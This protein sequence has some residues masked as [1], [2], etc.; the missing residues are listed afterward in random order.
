MFAQ[1]RPQ[2]LRGAE[3]QGVDI[4]VAGLKRLL[5]GECEQVLGQ[6]RAPIRRLIDHGGDLE[7]LGP[8]GESLNHQFRGAGDDGEYVV[9]V[10]SHPAG[11]LADG[12]E[13]LRLPEL[14]LVLLGRGDVAIDHDRAGLGAFGIMDRTCAADHVDQLVA[15]RKRM[16]ISK[17]STSSPRMLRA[18]GLS[19]IGSG[20]TP[21]A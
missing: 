9:E 11:E 15:P 6:L 2:Q 17:S 21:S 5:A 1:R 13:L 10:M 8:V 4:D 20:V 7:Q 3:H 16:N 19:W 18:P 14:A 12:I